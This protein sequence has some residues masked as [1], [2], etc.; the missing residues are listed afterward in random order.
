MEAL[1]GEMEGAREN[2]LRQV[3]DYANRSFSSYFEEPAE[4]TRW[5]W[6]AGEWGRGDGYRGRVHAR[7]DEWFE[8][9]QQLIEQVKAVHDRPAKLWQHSVVG[10]LEAA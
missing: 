1:Q 8:N 4:P 2:F 9:D 3:Q 6:I 5:A 10:R 7:F